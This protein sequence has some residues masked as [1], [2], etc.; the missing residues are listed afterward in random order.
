[1]YRKQAFIVTEKTSWAEN[2]DGAAIVDRHEPCV[3]CQPER[4]LSV[5]MQP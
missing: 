3:D 4:C 2:K 1:M 5:G